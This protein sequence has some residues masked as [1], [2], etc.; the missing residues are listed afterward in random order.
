MVMIKKDKIV[1]IIKKD[2]P[3]TNYLVTS[4]GYF[5]NIPSEEY[6]S[7]MEIPKETKD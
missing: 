7:M 5:R 3:S 4:G 1:S 2:P 6:Q